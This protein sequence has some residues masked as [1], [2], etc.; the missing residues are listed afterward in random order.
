MQ[1]LM[2]LGITGTEKDTLVFYSTQIDDG[3]KEGRT[4]S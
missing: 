3:H 2:I 1:D 4:K